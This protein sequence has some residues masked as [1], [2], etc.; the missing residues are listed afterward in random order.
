MLQDLETCCS[1]LFFKTGMQFLIKGLVQII[2]DNLFAQVGAT[3]FVSQDIAQSRIIFYNF[4]AVVLTGTG[5]RTKNTGNALG[6]SANGPGRSGKIGGNFGFT[7]RKQFFEGGTDNGDIFG[8]TQPGSI[9][10]D[11]GDRAVLQSGYQLL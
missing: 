11:L 10:M 6:I 1:K 5:S 3:A 4:F 2:L 8:T 9:K 7:S